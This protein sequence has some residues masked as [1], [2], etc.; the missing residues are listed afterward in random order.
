MSNVMP[1]VGK[2]APS[3]TLP[4][5]TGDKVKLTDLR[6]KAVIVYFYP[7]DNTPGCTIEAQEFQAN[8]GAFKK[9]GAVV[10]G[11]S[12]DPVKSHCKFADKF[13][14]EFALLADEDHKV[15]ERY[16]VWVE[17]NNYGKKYMGVQRATFLVDNEG[18]LAQIWPKVKAKGHA[19]EVLEAVRAL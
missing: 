9:A 19:A 12:P 13:G 18:I 3:I 16:G 1:E 4:S 2:K 15:C 6:G 11:I 5:T 17:K 8:L 14:L 10:L 7:K